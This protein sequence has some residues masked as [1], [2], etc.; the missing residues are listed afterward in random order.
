LNRPDFPRWKNNLR[1]EPARKERIFGPAKKNIP[2]PGI[3][4]RRRRV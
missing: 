2:T 3:P 1:V 4:F